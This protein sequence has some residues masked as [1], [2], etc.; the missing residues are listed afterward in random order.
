M[1][2][3]KGV[4]RSKREFGHGT[5]GGGMIPEKIEKTKGYDP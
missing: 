2:R 5:E 3:R 4:S 1:L